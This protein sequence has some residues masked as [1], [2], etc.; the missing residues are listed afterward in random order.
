MQKKHTLCDVYNNDSLM[1]ENFHEDE[2]GYL[3]GRAVVT[4]VGVFPYLNADGSIFNELRLPEDV[5]AESAL[6]SLR[7]VPIT[8]DH[9]SEL[10]TAD[11]VKKYQV[12][13]TGE[14]VCRADILGE[15]EFLYKTDG[16]QVT[17][18]MK[19]FDKETIE[20]IK[21]GKR[22]LSCG[23]T[24]ELEETRGVWGGVAYD[25]IQRNITYNHVAV[26]DRGRAGDTAVMK[27]DNAL[28]PTYFEADSTAEPP[29]VGAKTD[30]GNDNKEAMH[31][32]NLILDSVTY[33]VDEKVE[34]A[35]KAVVAERD[36]VK[37]QL[38]MAN[39]KI[40]TLQKDMEGMI[41]A[42]VLPQK[43]REYQEIKETADKFGVSL[44]ENASVI[45]M[46]RAVIKVANPA[47]ADSIDKASDDYV[48]GA[49]AFCVE[50]NVQ[51]SHS[52]EDNSNEDGADGEDGKEKKDSASDIR[53]KA[54]DKLNSR[55]AKYAR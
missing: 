6:N 18:S 15:C 22:A 31:M 17:I 28:V 30:K 48:N 12:G 45:D 37:G 14:D 32:A 42:D 3:V 50:K 9:P 2:N 36:S 34:A 11:N 16:T 47:I 54:M 21:A 39:T 20:A 5:F 27:L 41:K 46:K 24:C 7:L 23:Y 43:V 29:E 19:I 33:E 44:D 55:L 26:V 25:A 49:F 52:D 10:V 8:N 4:C 38:D 51:G 35:Y 40:E 53:T 13:T 1:T